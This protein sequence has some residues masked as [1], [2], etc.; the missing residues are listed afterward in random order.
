MAVLVL[1]LLLTHH[2]GF[3]EPFELHFTFC[4]LTEIYNALIST[5]MLYRDKG[6]TGIYKL[7]RVVQLWGAG[8]TITNVSSPMLPRARNTVGN[9][10]MYN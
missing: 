9:L 5:G 4:P 2:G 6:C 10:Y 1:E 7:P 8:V 3:S